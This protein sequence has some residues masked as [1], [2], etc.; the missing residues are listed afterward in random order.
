MCGPGLLWRNVLL[1][2]TALV[3]VSAV[4]SRAQDVAEAAQQT[5]AQGAAEQS[6]AEKKIDRHVYTEEELKRKTILTPEDKARVE[7]RRKKSGGVSG[8]QNAERLPKKEE[9]E[10]ESLGEMARRYR[11]EKAAREAE[12]AAQK[13]FRPFAYDVLVNSLAAPAPPVAP[14]NTTGR[15]I[16]VIGGMKPAVPDLPAHEAP[17]AAARVRISPFQPRPLKGVS[18][19][20]PAALVVAPETPAAPVI[21]GPAEKANVVSARISGTQR[22]QAQRGQSWW[23]L[24]E[25]YLGDGARWQELR[26]MNADV[27]GPAELL[28]LGRTIVVPDVAQTHAASEKSVKVSQGDS[29]WSLAQK[30]LGRGSAWTCLAEANPAIVDYTRLAVG[31]L[32]QVPGRDA[33]KSCQS[34]KTETNTR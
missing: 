9:D 27:E 15:G 22:V 23:R 2:T 3:C 24:A 1:C 14:L 4:S 25:Q 6:P 8:E 11:A 17:R 5:K 32:V 16:P 34:R 21:T 33:G 13:K 20:P 31:T 29:L 26:R 28:P 12:L 18:A 30:Y 19:V 10:S 7:A